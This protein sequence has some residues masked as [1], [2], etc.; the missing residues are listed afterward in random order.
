MTQVAIYGATGYGGQE[1]LRLLAAHPEFDVTVVTSTRLEGQCV[2]DVHEQLAGFYKDLHFTAPEEAHDCEA[3]F[4]AVPH[5]AAAP[6]MERVEGLKVVDL[7]MDFRDMPGEFAYGLTE[8]NRDKIAEAKRVANPGC[9]ATGAILALAPLA[10]V[11]DGDV[12][13][14]QTTG[15][16]GSGAH[17]KAGTHHPERAQDQRAYRVLTHQHEPEVKR[18]LERLGATN[19]DV[20]MIPQSGPFSRGIF[21][22]AHMRVPEDVD[23]EAL[24]RERYANEFF[25]RMRPTT[26]ALRHVARSNFC[27]ISVHRRGDRVVVL[28]A[29]DNLGKGMAGQAIQNMNLLF[30]L[31]ETEG[32]KFP[33]ANA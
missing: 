22:V 12:T 15:S 26:P 29:I 3:A 6:L 33:G 28:S 1:L 19:F 18:E 25:V 2:E 8:T 17:A 31:D 14:A 16:S 21:T 9:F 10:D 4:L 5:G 20:A 7:S 23:V 11:L 32:L 30:G 27:D 24:Y 13:L